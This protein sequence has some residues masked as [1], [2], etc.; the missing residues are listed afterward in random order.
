MG[1]NI[2]P[3]QCHDCKNH[4]WLWYCTKGHAI[5]NFGEVECFDRSG[6]EVG[7]ELR[8]ELTSN[9]SDFNI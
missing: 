8:A 3:L 6:A 2:H 4:R 9:V 7:V 1:T 5:S